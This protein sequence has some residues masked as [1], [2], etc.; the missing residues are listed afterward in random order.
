MDFRQSME[1]LT[2]ALQNKKIVAE[3]ALD[4]VLDDSLGDLLNAVI[5]TEFYPTCVLR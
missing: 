5:N 3:Q 4:Q 1:T 2:S